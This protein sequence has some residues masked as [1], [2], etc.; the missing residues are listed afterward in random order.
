M[1]S[2]SLESW[3]GSKLKIRFW[4]ARRGGRGRP[5]CLGRPGA[6]VVTDVVARTAWGAAAR[7]SEGNG[8]GGGSSGRLGRKSDDSSGGGGG[9][10]GRSR[11]PERGCEGLAS[12]LKAV[13]RSS[14]LGASA[15]RRAGGRRGPR[16]GRVGARGGAGRRS[17]SRGV[18]RR[19][20]GQLRRRWW[21]SAAAGGGP[22][23]P[24]V[25]R[26]G[27]S[28]VVGGEVD[29]GTARGALRRPVVGWLQLL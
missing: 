3:P 21:W 23:G 28:G 6:A 7:V 20:L 29:V 12:P 14:R 22:R 26:R 24:D 25:E 11:R 15:L 2:G 17:G 27:L 8:G 13:A 5:R 16:R 9:G 19:G 10:G 4:P 18:R 1:D